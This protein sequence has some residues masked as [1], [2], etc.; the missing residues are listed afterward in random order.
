MSVLA[1]LRIIKQF[2]TVMTVTKVKDYGTT[3]SC[4]RKPLK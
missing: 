2:V 1:N 3:K 4:E